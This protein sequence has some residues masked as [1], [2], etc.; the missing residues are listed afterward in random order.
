MPDVTHAKVDDK[1]KAWID[2][3]LAEAVTALTEQGVVESIMIEAK[4][5]WVLPHRILI[6][7]LRDSAIRS[8]FYWFTCGEVPI[9]CLPS[10]VATSPREAAR[11]FSLK[12][13]LDAARSD[14]G[15]ADLEKS[16][17]W[18]YA[19]ADDGRLW[20]GGAESGPV[21]DRQS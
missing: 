10:T 8:G 19:L 5:A 2:A 6:G 11:H 20:F 15:G 4:P 1:L 18:M 13:Q 12:W 14:E 17:E 3:R 7:K 9:D 21:K 16:A